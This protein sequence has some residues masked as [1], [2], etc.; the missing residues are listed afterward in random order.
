MQKFVGEFDPAVVVMD[1]ISDLVRLGSGDRRVRTAD[2]A[3]R[4]PQGQGGDSALHEPE[5]PRRGAAGRSADGVARRHVA[6]SSRRWRATASTT[7]SCTSSSPAGWPTPT[8]SASSC[9]PDQG[10]ELADVYVGPQGVL[11]GSARQAQEAKERLDGAA[12]LEELEHR[13]VNL[14]RRREAVEA[15]TRRCGESSLTRPTSWSAC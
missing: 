15:Q 3:G 12:G 10:I 13:R 4:L 8:R 7:G 14:A 11:T 6:A 1:P 5:L 9:S 2:P